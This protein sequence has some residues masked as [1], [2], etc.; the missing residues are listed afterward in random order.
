MAAWRGGRSGGSSWASVKDGRKAF[1]TEDKKQRLFIRPVGWFEA[2]PDRRGKFSASVQKR[3]LASRKRKARMADLL[4]LFQVLLIDMTL[5]G[6]NAV[7]VGLAVAGLPPALTQRA[8][9]AGLGAA[10]LIRVA[11]SVVAI[12]L[13]AMIGLT[14]AGGVLLLWV[15]WKMF[16]ELR[17]QHRRRWGAGG[18]D[19]GPGDAADR[20]RRSV[21][22][23]GQRAGGRRRRART[24][25]VMVGGLALSVV[26]MALAGEPGGAAAAAFR[27]DRLG[28]PGG[29][30][31][32]LRGDDRQRLGA[33][34]AER[35]AA[36]R[37][38]CTQSLKRRGATCTPPLRISRLWTC[39]APRSWLPS[40][41]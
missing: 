8:I 27:L 34:H 9:L 21:H 3:S 31:V 22:E 40:G 7:V 16:R 30:A 37:P 20:A 12:R 18:E 26:L 6:D 32:R 17:A 14:L 13:L 19:A 5:A 41:W 35:D 28:R 10:A 29:G 25:W 1:W 2:A 15:C 33:G 39:S 11:L 23:P 36:D 38:D 24:C 4:A